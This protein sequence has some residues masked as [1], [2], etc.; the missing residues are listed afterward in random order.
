MSDEKQDAVKRYQLCYR[1]G[2]TDYNRRSDCNHPGSSKPMVLAE[3]YD[4]IASEK[5]EL[6]TTN[7]NLSL[8]L[9]ELVDEKIAI[10]TAFVVAQ[11]ERDALARQNAELTTSRDNLRGD[12]DRAIARIAALQHRLSEVEAD[13]QRL[14]WLVSDAARGQ[15]LRVQGNDQRGWRVLDMSHGLVIF[16]EGKTARAAIDAASKAVGEKP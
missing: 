8:Q 7:I 5:A 6:E 2:V 10:N 16:G 14:D 3:A 15:A 4:A 12:R 1:C 11:E 13:A 9:G